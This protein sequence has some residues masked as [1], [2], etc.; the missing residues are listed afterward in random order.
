MTAGDRRSAR[1]DVPIRIRVTM[2]RRVAGPVKVV[3][4]QDLVFVHSS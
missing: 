2:M 1:R 4:G 3:A